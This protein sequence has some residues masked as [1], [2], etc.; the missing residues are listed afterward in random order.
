MSPL[1]VLG[2]WGY[3]TLEGSLLRACAGLGFR[4]MLLTGCGVQPTW[5][6][7]TVQLSAKHP[8]QGICVLKL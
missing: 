5:S 2:S 7:P 3:E 4:A 1:R 8:T 6:T